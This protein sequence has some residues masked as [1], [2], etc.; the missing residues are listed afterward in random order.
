VPGFEWAIRALG[1]AGSR[2]LEVS[3]KQDGPQPHRKM[4]FSV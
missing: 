3:L 2:E 1:I 4:L